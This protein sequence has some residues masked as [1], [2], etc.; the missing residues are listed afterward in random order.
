M[1][2]D[3]AFGTLRVAPDALTTHAY[4]C[5]PAL[6]RDA[7]CCAR[8]D[9]ALTHAEADR[10]RDRLPE[11]LPFCPWLQEDG[12]LV[13]PFHLTPCE[14]IL[15]KR[16]DGTCLLNHQADDGRLYCAVHSWALAHGEN[17]FAVKPLA[18]SLWPF[19]RDGADRC[20][21]D[22]ESAPPCLTPK[23]DPNPDPELLALLTSIPSTSRETG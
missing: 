2:D 11:L 18:C 16:A 1:P 8:F 20:T 23:S 7:S 10:I 6:C 21:L 15:R 5:D 19:V 17:P 22:H 4:R 12:Q 14:I 13:D 9:V 3:L